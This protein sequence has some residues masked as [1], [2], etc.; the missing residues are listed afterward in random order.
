MRMWCRVGCVDWMCDGDG[1]RRVGMRCAVGKM[2]CNA[3]LENRDDMVQ[4]EG[5]REYREAQVICT[6]PTAS[7]S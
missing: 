5:G 6:T 4:G 3:T 7:S 2:Q 1:C